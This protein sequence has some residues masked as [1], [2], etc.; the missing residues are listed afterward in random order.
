MVRWIFWVSSALEVCGHWG[1]TP[2]VLTA[3]LNAHSECGNNTSDDRAVPLIA[4][5]NPFA[6]RVGRGQL[7]LH[8]T[9]EDPSPVLV[10]IQVHSV[11]N[12]LFDGARPIDDR[13]VIYVEIGDHLPETIRVQARLIDAAGQLSSWSEASEIVDE[14][15]GGCACATAILDFV[16][17]AYAAWASTTSD[18]TDLKSRHAWYILADVNDWVAR[19]AQQRCCSTL[20]FSCGTLSIC[21]S[22]VAC[23]SCDPHK[24]QSIGKPALVGMAISASAHCIKDDHNTTIITAW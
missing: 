12:R 14:R 17:S 3:Y 15:M 2:P 24:L 20:S 7:R 1:S 18:S 9:H 19:P 22:S 23:T 21:S 11:E 6:S 10:H 13:L 8:L 16:C 5:C 4:E